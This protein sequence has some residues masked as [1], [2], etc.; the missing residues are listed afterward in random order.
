MKI[1]ARLLEKPWGQVGIPHLIGPAI[2]SRIGEVC[3]DSPS[4]QSLPVLIKYLYTSERLSIQVHPDDDQARALGHSSGKDE[5]WIVLD[6]EP[7]ST[8]GMGLKRE[9]TKQELRQALVDGTIEELV[10]WRAAARGDVIY[11]PA[12]TVHAA[13]A[14][15]VL[16]EIQQAI[17]LTYRLYDYGRPRKLHV[18]EGLAVARPRPHS[19]PR[20]G[21]VPE[22]GS[23]IL[24]DGPHFGVAWCNGELPVEMPRSADHYQ[25]VVVEG[26]AQVAGCRLGVGECGLA[27]S[28]ADVKLGASTIAVIAWPA[29]TPVE[30]PLTEMMAHAA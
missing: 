8:I 7:G 18:E 25:L 12:G 24:V 11:N 26:S 9:T 10:N 17:D 20:D 21:R 6:A 22:R 4:G 2:D 28:L 29:L 1:E 19:D 15:L 23:A 14:G 13:G 27:G 5:M 3:F 30:S 16:L